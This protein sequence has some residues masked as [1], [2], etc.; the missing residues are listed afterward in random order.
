MLLKCE[1]CGHEN[2]L[3]SIFCRECGE[4][5]AINAIRPEVDSKEAINV[6]GIVRKIVTGIIVLIAIYLVVMMFIPQHTPRNLL[7]SDQQAKAS[8]KFKAMM[9]KIDGRYGE[10]SYR[11]TSS[12]VTYLY[13]NKIAKNDIYNIDKIYFSIDSRNFV[14]VIMQHKLM[15]KIPVTFSLKG[16]LPE[17]STNFTVRDVQ[18]GRLGLPRFLKKTI[19]SQFIPMT[20][21]E[22]VKKIIDGS[23]AFE[24][25]DGDFIV[26]LNKEE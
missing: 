26:I 19:V 12:E 5:L 9:K 20:E 4:K 21:K 24:I 2:Q 10:N 1:K 6:F 18:M 23:V 3:G 25:K 22:V 17:G 13:N 7:T 16:V 14:H 15:G 11:F 8:E